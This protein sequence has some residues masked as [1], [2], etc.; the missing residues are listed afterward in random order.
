MYGLSKTRE[1]A[2]RWVY[3]CHTERGCLSTLTAMHVSMFTFLLSHSSHCVPPITAATR[4][5]S[6]DGTPLSCSR[7]NGHDRQILFP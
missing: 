2:L 5:H 6:L 7:D 1:A 4:G 3:N